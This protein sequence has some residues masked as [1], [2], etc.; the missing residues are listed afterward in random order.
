LI[1]FINNISFNIMNKSAA[2][3]IL[4]LFFSISLIPLAM[5]Q[6]KPSEHI[7]PMVN[8][9]DFIVSLVQEIDENLV[10]SY[11]SELVAFGP[12]YT[13]TD[14]CSQAAQYIYNNFRDFGLSAQIEPWE[15]AGYKSQNVVGELVGTNQSDAV[16]LMTAHYDTVIESPGADDDASGVAAVLAAAH[17]MC[18]YTFVHT[19]RFVAFSGEEVGTYGSFHHAR[20]AYERGDNIVAVINIDMVGYAE[21]TRGGRL[22]RVFETRRTQW[23][24]ELLIEVSSRYSKYVDLAVEP[25]PNYIGADHQAF[26]DYGYDAVF[27]AHYDGYRWGHSRND[28]LDHI[29]ITYQ[30]KATRLLLA[31]VA[32]LASQS[33]PLQVLI[34]APC[35]GCF[36]LGNFSIFSL[37]LGWFWFLQLRGITVAVGSPLAMAE[38]RSTD[39][40]D[41][42]IFCLDDI[43]ITWD[44]TPPYH[45]R[46][47]GKH[48]PFIGRHVL[49]VYAYDI[50]GR[51]AS[52]EMD[53]ILYSLAYQYAPWN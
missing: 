45:W 12:R 6:V 41:Y 27:C 43:F 25:I 26:L 8:E 34:T 29:N 47:E 28:T 9:F 1:I 53:I 33:I 32:T 31:M 11:L 19:I 2:V 24:S 17:V 23:L 52:D 4:F 10:Y 3:A 30:T 20:W 16:V 36:Y 51:V 18:K 40:V 7:N 44:R 37:P 13:G 49:R 21:S 5:S 48:G 14:N 46:I 22:L 50:R 35:E 38:V 42:V 15:Y 39:D